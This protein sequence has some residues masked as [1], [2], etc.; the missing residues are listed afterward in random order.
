MLTKKQAFYES[1]NSLSPG[2]VE[3]IKKAIDEAEKSYK[4]KLSSGSGFLWEHTSLVASLSFKL[5]Q[6]EKEDANLAA[7]VALFHD[8][9][10]FDDG[11][12]HE[13]E[14]TEEELG[15]R[16]ARQVLEQAGLGLT[17][18]GRV[19]RG[20]KSL[21]NQKE[22]NRLADIVHDAD[23]LNK[24]GYLGVANFFI[25]S[26]LR[27]KNLEQALVGFLSRELT[28]ASTMALNM[29]TDSG[30]KLAEKKAEDTFRFYRSLLAELKTVHNVEFRVH[31][32][33][34][35]R[36]GKKQKPV[37]VYLVV[38]VCCP[39]CSGKWDIDLTS[40]KGVKCEKAEAVIACISCDYKY[41]VS[42]CL[43][44]ISRKKVER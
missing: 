11:K 5:A 21:Y 39:R 28:Y 7:L 15:A 3:R 22:N 23:F 18:I 1:L 35:K 4:S 27:G 10:K 29:R 41:S 6:A 38:P 2:L 17:V 44:E 16:L 25:K 26:T 31:L 42:F 33:E 12:Y 36:V 40:G 8:A 34:V 20:I 37:R 24:S 14:K 9:G 13:G 30:L 19:V 43:P 32:N